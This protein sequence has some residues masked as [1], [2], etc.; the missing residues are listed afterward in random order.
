MPYSTGGVPRDYYPV[1]SVGLSRVRSGHRRCRLIWVTVIVAVL[2]APATAAVAS[3]PAVDQYT[4]H[5][6]EAGGG[7]GAASGETPVARLGLLSHK[8]TAALSGRDGKLLAQIATARDL[9]APAAEGAGTGVT[10]ADGRGFV[11]VLADTAGTGPSLALIGAL[12]GIALAGGIRFIRRG[13]S[14]AHL[15]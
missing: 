9:G 11:S 2:A 3:P 10:S 12:V 15:S 6:P 5:L 1:H 7:S 13:R 4:Q 8:T 14:S